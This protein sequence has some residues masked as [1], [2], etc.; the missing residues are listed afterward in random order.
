MLHSETN[1]VVIRHQ[2]LILLSKKVLIFKYS[3]TNILNS[4][5]LASMSAELFAIL[6]FSQNNSCKTCLTPKLPHDS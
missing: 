3:L 4:L 5:L 2:W 1:L 6:C